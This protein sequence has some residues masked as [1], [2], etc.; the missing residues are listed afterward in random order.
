MY[1]TLNC[2][3]LVLQPPLPL[4]L[5]DVRRAAV[6]VGEDTIPTLLVGWE[7]PVHRAAAVW[8]VCRNA[9]PALGVPPEMF[10]KQYTCIL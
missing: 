6:A 2:G 1:T 5:N 7:S 9:L 10:E 3:K 8:Q 4:A